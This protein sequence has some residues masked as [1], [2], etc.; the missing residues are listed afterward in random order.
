MTYS[1]DFRRGRNLLCFFRQLNP[2]FRP[3]VYI[4]GFACR[5]VVCEIA[6]QLLYSRSGY[7][8]LS[9]CAPLSDEFWFSRN[10]ALFFLPL[11]LISFW[12]CRMHNDDSRTRTA[13]GEGEKNCQNNHD[14][15]QG[16]YSELWRTFAWFYCSTA[17]NGREFCLGQQDDNW[18]KLSVD[19]ARDGVLETAC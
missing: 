2:A 3:L 11:L 7:S 17:H 13:K 18:T 15:L 12:R 16:S 6:S 14:R 19:A 4:H 8:K 5:S 10:C 9:V 1:C